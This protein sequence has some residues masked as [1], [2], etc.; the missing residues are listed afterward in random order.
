MYPILAK[1]YKLKNKIQNYE[2]GTKN[3][4]AFIPKMLGIRA[5]KDVPYAELWIGSHP[6]SPSEIEI[7]GHWISLHDAIKHSPELILGKSVYQKFGPQ[8][9]FLLKVL[10]AAKALSIQLHPNKKQA[11]ELHRKD[12]KN[13][14]DNNHKPEIAITLDHLQALAG[15]LLI[16][17]IR[18]NLTLHP[19][20]AAFAGKESVD[21]VL[22]AENEKSA[23][24]SVKKLYSAIMN[25]AENTE[26][27]TTVIP[28]MVERLSLSG[29][30]SEADL[31]FL[32]QYR[33]FGSDVG[34][35]SF[36]FFNLLDLK[37]GQ[38]IFTDAG[39]PH[40]YIGG[41]IIE[42][43]ANSDNVVRAGLTPKFKDV[44][45]LLDILVYT[46][47]PF[48][49]LNKNQQMDQ[50]VY[51]TTSP[52]LE[53]TGYNK[54]ATFSVAMSSQNKPFIGLITDGGLS[55]SWLGESVRFE[56]GESFLIP[57]CLEK[58]T[59]H[60]ESQVSFYTVTVPE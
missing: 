32:N 59:I 47:S 23:E 2:W 48:D 57:A 13:Y 12:S 8:L 19:E 49:I 36:Y 28:K 56:K 45:T 46:F 54:K 1:P 24:E 39:I 31:Q 42:C 3:E 9:P 22:S 7:N 14:P 35:F 55:V 41:N 26:R 11:E 34:L 30:H 60:S 43:M 38:A 10:S 29:S 37:P 20:I 25:Q 16:T 6:K 18:K 58:F 40:A 53:V 21:A 51:K 17:D 50:F 15:F 44:S 52:E 5:E 4:Q 33:L 27:L